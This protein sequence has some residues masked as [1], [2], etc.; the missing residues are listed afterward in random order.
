MATDRMSIFPA[1]EWEAVQY[2]EDN[3]PRPRGTSWHDH[4]HDVADLVDDGMS[5]R[6]GFL[7]GTLA[8]LGLTLDE[9]LAKTRRRPGTSHRPYFALRIRLVDGAA[10]SKRKARAA[11][12]PCSR[13]SPH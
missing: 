4:L 3:F 5:I 8:T 7:M 2:I 11:P 6:V 13:P 12:P 9:F 10:S 1:N